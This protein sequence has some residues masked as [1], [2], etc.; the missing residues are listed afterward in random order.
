MHMN[1]WIGTTEDV[2]RAVL[3]ERFDVALD[4]EDIIVF[5][6]ENHPWSLDGRDSVSIQELVGESIIVRER[7]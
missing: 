4:S 5:V 6:N 3:E 1:L 2:Q 7:G